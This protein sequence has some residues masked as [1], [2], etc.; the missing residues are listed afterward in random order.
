MSERRQTLLAGSGTASAS[1]EAIDLMEQAARQ[2]I[3]TSGASP[4]LLDLGAIIVPAGTWG[5]GDPGRELARRLGAPQARS[6]LGQLGISQQEL[7]NIAIEM[8]SGGEADSILVVGG[9]SRRWATSGAMS[10]LDGT[11]DLVLE[12]PEHFIDDLEITSGLI[13][14]A[15]RSYALLERALDAR[16]GLDDHAAAAI[17]A[18]LWSAMSTVAA[19]TPGAVV[20]TPVPASE[21][22]ALTPSNRLLSAPYLR[23]HASQWTVDQAAALVITSHDAARAAGV[24][25]SAVVHPLVALESTDSVPVIHRAELDRWPAMGLLGEVAARQIGRPLDEIDLIDLYSC[26]PVA[27][28]LQ[29]EELGLPL[30]RPLTVTG[31]MTFGGGPFNNY[32]IGSTAM[33]AERLRATDART[34]LV[35][36]V[37][38]LLT[39]PGLC[40]WGI[41]EPAV[42]G[43][44]EDLAPEA[45]RRTARVA[46]TMRP[47]GRAITVET[48]TA[49][50]DGDVTTAAVLG[51]D[52]EGSRHLTLLHDH[53]SFDRFCAAS[54]VGEPL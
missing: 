21:I 34:G 41:D 22:S 19:Q 7:I 2:A 35:T 39:K 16:L 47:D 1:A 45:A 42:P 24:D 10:E 44:V 31:G 9:E 23:T 28:R 52:D 54:C 27:V 29:A 14:P 37:S 40:V 13:F 32:V 12:R 25:P 5:Y 15:V 11:P 20:S 36:T 18:E 8:V 48:S 17:N 3:A 50:I 49:W 33:M 51:I 46:C 26:F 4:G 38:G 43:P 30:D 6:I 53:E